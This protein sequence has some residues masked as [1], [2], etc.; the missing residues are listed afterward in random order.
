MIDL[1][2]NKPGSNCQFY[3]NS[4]TLAHFARCAKIYKAWEF[5]RIQLVKVK[6]NMDR[7]LQCP[8]CIV[9]N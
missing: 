1:Q 8:T 4:R 2:G 7:S 9:T 5:Y 6:L 3:S